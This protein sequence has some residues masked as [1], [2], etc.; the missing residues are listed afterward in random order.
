M[1]TINDKT[2][3]QNLLSS[4]SYIFLLMMSLC[5]Y[6]KIEEN[7]DKSCAQEHMLRFLNVIIRR[8]FSNLPK[9][10]NYKHLCILVPAPF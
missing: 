5:P 9:S 8:N 6:L 10:S 3:N 1:R 4:N 2:V 7:K